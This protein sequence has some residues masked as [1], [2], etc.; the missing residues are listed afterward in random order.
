MP[1]DSGPLIAAKRWSELQVAVAV[2]FAS[3][4]PFLKNAGLGEVGLCVQGD[5]EPVA[6]TVE[7]DELAHKGLFVKL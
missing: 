7:E 5:G 6:A 3:A 4:H 1:A 2:G